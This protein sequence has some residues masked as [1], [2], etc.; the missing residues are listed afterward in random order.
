[1]TWKNPH[2]PATKK[3]KTVQSVGKVM[4]T[5][6]WM[7]TEFF[8]WFHTSHFNN[9]CNCLS[10]NSKETQ[11][12]YSVQE[13]RIVD[14][15]TRSS[16]F[17]RQC[18]TSQCCRNPESLL[19]L[20]LGN[21]STSTIRSWFGTVGLSSIPKDEKAPQR[22]EL[23]IQWICSKWSQEMV[24]CRGRIFFC[25]RLDKLRYRYDKCLNRLGDYVEK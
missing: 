22:S 1:M 13:T 8:G 4:A 16:S 11:G 15:R 23:P 19:L 18:S 21:S 12:G 24:T 7:F 5:V 6:F 25:E 20:G 9:K 17:A 3:F 14:R 2:S 10:G